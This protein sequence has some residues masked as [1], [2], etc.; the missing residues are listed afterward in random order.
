V[1]AAKLQAAADYLL[2]ETG[3]MNA[4]QLLRLARRVRDELDQ[5]G[6]ARRAKTQHDARSFRIWRQADGMYRVTALLDPEDGR[7]VQ[8]VFDQASSPRRGG[9]RFIDPEEKAQAVALEN[10]ERS[11]EQLSA[12]A[13]LALLRLGVDADPC[14]IIIGRRRPAVRVVVTEKTLK[15]RAGIGRLEGHPDPVPFE[16]VERQLCDTGHIG[17]KFDDDGQCVNVGREQR[18]F[19]ERQRTGIS[20][21]DGGCRWPGCDRPASW[22]ELHHID[23]WKRDHG[24]TDIALG[25]LLCRFH[26]LLLHNNHWDVLRTGGDY[27]LRPPVSVDPAQKLRPMPS[28]EPLMHQIFAHKAERDQHRPDEHRATG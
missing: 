12:D 10:D 8:T 22:S 7:F 6:I 15:D 23:Q 11:T 5:D 9:P 21:R 26:H 27:W 2:G 28:K 16:T 14:A 3:A 4:D 17:V 13:F 19:T 1:P 18:R 24:Q 20:V 25:I